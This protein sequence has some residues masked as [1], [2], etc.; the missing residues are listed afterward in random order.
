LLKFLF[1]LIA[2]GALGALALRWG[3]RGV[4]PE[5]STVAPDFALYDA[6]HRQ[7]RLADYRGSWLVLYFYP[8]DATPTCTAEACNLRD[9]H[10]EFRARGVALLGVS[11]DTAASHAEFGQQHRLTFP[12][13][14]DPDATAARAYGSLWDFGFLRFAKRHTFLIDPA[15]RVAKVYREIAAAR[16]SQEILADLTRFG[17]VAASSG[18]NNQSVPSQ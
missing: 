17:V 7:H 6:E 14:A 5:A 16:H 10:A 15:G 3:G 12:L 4:V 11:L 13:L 18:A 2:L 8:K 9:S 1:V